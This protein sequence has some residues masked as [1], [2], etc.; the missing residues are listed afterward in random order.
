MESSDVPT[1]PFCGYEE[2]NDYQML[3]HVEVYHAENG[4][5]PFAIK[6]EVAARNQ[7]GANRED[8]SSHTPSGTATP[9][10]SEYVECPYKCG[11]R[12]PASELQYHNDFHLAEEVA[13]E[14]PIT[15]V[16]NSFSTSISTALRNLDQEQHDS[17]D[18]QQRDQ[19]RT[20][21]WMA[22]LS[23]PPKAEQTR[24]K[25]GDVRRLSVGCSLGPKISLLTLLQKAEL[26]PYANEKRMPPWLVK[27]L[28][29]GAKVT[30]SNTIGPDGSLVRRETVAN[31]TPNLVPILARLSQLDPTILRASY[32]DP[33]VCHV[34]KLPKE[35]GFCG[36]RNI[37][38]QVSYVR[39]ARAPGHQHFEGRWLP[40]ILKLQDMIEDGWDRGY[41]TAARV[42]TGGI[43]MT[44]K[45]IGTAE[46]QALYLSLGMNSEA[47]A[48]S[49]HS[50]SDVYLAMMGAVCNYFNDDSA[51]NFTEKIVMTDKPP[52]FFQHQGHSMTVVGVELDTK[53]STNL[54]VFDPT[55]N[56][57]PQ[58]KRLALSNKTNFYSPHPAK[59]LKAHRRDERYLVRHKA[60]EIV[61][62]SG[63]KTETTRELR[64]T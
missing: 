45:Y 64:E 11:E 49:S 2:R 15:D 42:E 40:S 60:F 14:E 4:D 32:C 17:R 37:Q 12:V 20:S 25:A 8:T 21:S 47:I 55:C 29:D 43:R 41:N 6:D 31:E 18:T 35:G 50:K 34:A 22:W 63:L 10:R 38:M 23:P 1:C 16:T 57:A 58:L 30:I 24:S 51:P 53:G 28:Q 13:M 27:L 61:K 46:A 54:V 59:L 36:Y 39:D 19:R 7:E 3:L 5:S 52:L 33:R 9:S 48:F 56:P 44:R 62:V 26:G